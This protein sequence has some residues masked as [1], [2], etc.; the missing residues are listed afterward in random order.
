MSA[1]TRPQV[2]ASFPQPSAEGCPM[3]KAR[4]LDQLLRPTAAGLTSRLRAW[5]AGNVL[6]VIFL[7]LCIGLALAFPNFATAKNAVLILQSSA[8]I[9]VMALGLAFVMIGGG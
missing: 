5:A 7:L 6:T 3:A 2:V 4:E 1:P 9:G 8:I